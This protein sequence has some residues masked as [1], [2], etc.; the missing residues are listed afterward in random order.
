MEDFVRNSGEGL[1]VINLTTVLHCSRK[2]HTGT[3]VSGEK[4]SYSQQARSSVQG[5]GQQTP[6]P[7]REG[8]E[9]ASQ[10]GTEDP[11]CFWWDSVET[12]GTVW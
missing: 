6:R 5:D 7:G 8:E 3:P 10:S 12:L 9:E 1:N 11:R 2:E 4:F